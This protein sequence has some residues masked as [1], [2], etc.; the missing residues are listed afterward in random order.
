MAQR[1]PTNARYQKYTKPEGKTRRSAASA[2]PKRDSGKTAAV[3]KSSSKSA[4]AQRKV[5]V[6]TS[7]EYRKW[8]NIWWACLG[9]GFALALVSG[10]AFLVL[11]QGTVARPVLNGILFV[12]YGFLI[13]SMFIDYKRVRPARDA[14]IREGQTVEKGSKDARKSTTTSGS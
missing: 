9:V 1:S 2:K 3:S 10:I 11:P 8:R 13:A 5:V 4:A 6:P 12:C 14:A 7:P